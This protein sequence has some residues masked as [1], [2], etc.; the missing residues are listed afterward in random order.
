MRAM[1]TL[2]DALRLLK[3]QSRPAELDG[4]ARFGMAVDR[5]LGVSVPALRRIG[6]QLGRDHAL[7]MEL[8][9]TGIPDAQILASLVAEPQRFNARQMDAWAKSMRS[10][11]VCD[12]ACLNAFADSP[13]AWDKV[14]A[15]TGQRDEFVRRAGFALLAVLA[16]HDKEAPDSRFVDALRLIEAAAG[17]ERN[18]V[19]KAVNW[20]LRGIG[21]RN[22]ALNAAAIACAER[23][24]QIDSRAARW[25]A[26][27]AL[28]EL[29]SDAVR[30]R[31][32]LAS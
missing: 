24:Q 22:A 26:A 15:W 29:R 27:D 14:A 32:G 31:L 12:G 20:A 8:W 21:K 4:M 23:L 10:W 30:R 5:R 16:V 9:D 6:K 17:D 11:D 3:E 19:K 2:D 13:L 25:I 7:A 18:F 28:R 1:P